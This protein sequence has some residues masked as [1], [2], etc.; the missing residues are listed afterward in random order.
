MVT[1]DISNCCLF[2]ITI[3]ADKVVE[4]FITFGMFRRF[5]T[6]QHS[7]ETVGYTD[8]VDHLVLGITRMHI[9]SLEG[10]FG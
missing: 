4:T 1:D 3:K 2:H 6:G 8:R 10:N 9:A 5:V 7:T